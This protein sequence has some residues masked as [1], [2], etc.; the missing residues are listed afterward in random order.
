MTETAGSYCDGR[1]SRVIAVHAWCAGGELHVRGDGIERTDPLEAITPSAPLAGVPYTLR[2]PDGARLRLPPDAPVGQ[3][4]PRHH[5]LERRVDAWERRAGFAALA[6][7]VVGLALV[8]LFTWVV[9]AAADYGARQLPVAVDRAVGRQSLALLQTRWLEPSTLPQRRR[10]ELQRRF[11]TFAAHSGDRDPLRLEFYRSPAFGANAFSLGGGII[12]VTDGLVRALPDDDA[13]LAVVAHE[14]GHEHYRHTLRMVLRGSGV[15]I[16]AS[17]LMGDVSGA[18]LASAIPVFLLN[19]RYSRGFEQQADTY[20]FH[21]LEHAGIS[22]LA[23]V[24]AMQAL[25][26]SHP[27]LRQDDRIRYVSTH[28]VTAER[29]ARARQAARDFLRAGK[30]ARPSA[31][32][33][34]PPSSVAPGSSR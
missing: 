6:V 33:V 17:V 21:A 3:W 25:E 29:I 27:G 14:M 11:R 2:Y 24:R 20:A 31:P 10:D 28:P 30:T 12:V 32:T 26:K 9:P 1:T 19:A 8:V 23:F 13:F 34:P 7:L 4:F 18:T 16:V 15:A 5:R 22:P